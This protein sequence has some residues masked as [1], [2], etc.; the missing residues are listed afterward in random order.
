MEP[1]LV[2]FLDSSPKLK[3]QHLHMPVT[4]SGPMPHYFSVFYGEWGEFK[5]YSKVILAS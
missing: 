3:A 5:G 1:Y 4:H 2:C